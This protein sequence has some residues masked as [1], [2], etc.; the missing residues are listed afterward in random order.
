MIGA[1][2]ARR[3]AASTAKPRPN[4]AE[5]RRQAVQATVAWQVQLAA[6][7][8]AGTPRRARRPPSRPMTTATSWL[9]GRAHG[10]AE[11]GDP[12]RPA[13]TPPPQ[14]GPLPA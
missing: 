13:P 2:A 8:L 5:L 10:P 9:R 1:V 4:L 7:H 6:L 12:G 3:G 14:P 11:P